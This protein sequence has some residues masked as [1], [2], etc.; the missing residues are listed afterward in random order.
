MRETVCIIHRDSLATLLVAPFFLRF[1]YLFYYYYIFCIPLSWFLP[2]PLFLPPFLINDLK[3]GY[4]YYYF[5]T[6]VF[7]YFWGRTA[8]L[9]LL[10]YFYTNFSRPQETE[11]ISFIL[12]CLPPWM[13]GPVLFLFLLAYTFT[14]SLL[15]FP[16]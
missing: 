15:S 4:D 9:A 3:H 6:A 7:F 13:I 8:A 5:S 12:R 1:V 16:F 11:I 14:L 2:V 10:F